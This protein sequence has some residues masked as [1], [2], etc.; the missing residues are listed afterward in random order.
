MSE[1]PRG[2]A[3]S[4]FDNICSTGQWGASIPWEQ[5]KN[6]EPPLATE[7]E[8]RARGQKSRGL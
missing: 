1:L 7:V 3:M 4:S 6:F 5:V 2:W 8:T